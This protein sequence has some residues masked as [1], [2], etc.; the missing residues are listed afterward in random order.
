MHAEGVNYNYVKKVQYHLLIPFDGLSDSLVGNKK[1][2]GR[3]YSLRPGNVVRDYLRL[4]TLFLTLRCISDHSRMD[5][6]QHGDGFLL[7]M[8]LQAQNACWGATEVHITIGYC[9]QIN[10]HILTDGV[11]SANCICMLTL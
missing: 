10:G 1:L 8:P 6:G 4:H 9:L 2:V 11:H 3:I 5:C 7:I